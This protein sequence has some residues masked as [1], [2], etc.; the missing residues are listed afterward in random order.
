M[1]VTRKA[2]Q[3]LYVVVRSRRGVRR[4]RS[5][6]LFGQGGGHLVGQRGELRR[7]G[8]VDAARGGHGAELVR[9]VFQGDDLGAVVSAGLGCLAEVQFVALNL[10]RDERWRSD[11]RVPNRPRPGYFWFLRTN[12][13]PALRNLLISCVMIRPQRF[14]QVYRGQNH[15]TVC[16]CGTV[17]MHATEIK[18]FTASTFITFL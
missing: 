7:V 8:H 17:C 13:S 18:T 5:Q 14:T 11:I 10:W 4:A 3:L 16:T 9:G 12:D 15:Q 6:A 1:K 2:S